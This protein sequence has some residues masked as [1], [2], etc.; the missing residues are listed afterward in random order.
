MQ[1]MMQIHRP[2]LIGHGPWFNAK[3][4]IIVIMF[5]W[6]DGVTVEP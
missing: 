2:Q 4:L 1:M 6:C 5:R 3:K